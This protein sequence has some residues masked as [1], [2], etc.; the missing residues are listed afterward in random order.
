MKPI[1]YRLAQTE[2]ARR[3]GVSVRSIRRWQA[4]SA[5]LDSP[6]RMLTWLAARKHL[7]KGR[8]LR[9]SR[10]APPPEPHGLVTGAS[11]ALSRLER[12]EADAFQAMQTALRGDD[13]SALKL[14]RESWLKIGDSLRRYELAIEESRRESGQLVPRAEVEQ[15]LG[16]FARWCWW[17]GQRFAEELATRLDRIQRDASFADKSHAILRQIFVERY[18][19]TIAATLSSRDVPAWFTDALT[20]DIAGAYPD[21]KAAVD[22]RL[23]AL[24]MAVKHLVEAIGEKH[25]PS[26]KDQTPPE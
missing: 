20:V 6:K 4:E 12:A 13:P 24:E 1:K 18:L 26:P 14:A 21:A 2:Y 25:D 17:T 3:E 16:Q 19:S 11:A 22:G 15:L 23:S 9:P 10:P 8:A 5:P 7:P